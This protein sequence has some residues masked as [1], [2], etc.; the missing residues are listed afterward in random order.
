MGNEELEYV[1]D[2]DIENWVDRVRAIRITDL[3]LGG[4]GGPLNV[5]V[6]DNARRTRRLRRDA[7]GRA[8]VKMADNTATTA[9]RARLV[10]VRRDNGSGASN[11]YG[12]PGASTLTLE[13]PVPSGEAYTTTIAAHTTGS[14]VVTHRGVTVGTIA[15]VTV[16]GAGPA[17]VNAAT[18]IVDT[19]GAYLVGAGTAKSAVAITSITP[20]SA[21]A[22]V[23]TEFVMRG[24]G[25]LGLWRAS[26]TFLGR[27][28]LD[29]VDDD[30]AR[31]SLKPSDMYFGAGDT[32]QIDFVRSSGEFATII[33]PVITVT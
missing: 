29:V 27:Y 10:L 14:V 23:V 17:T 31:V 4:A 11:G 24:Y 22:D 21:P 6:T 16:G 1:I 32:F 2:A 19:S 15:G 5:G 26:D 20:T 8:V 18:F 7:A 33:T 28:T 30:E 13:L 25:F 9:P 12:G 3:V